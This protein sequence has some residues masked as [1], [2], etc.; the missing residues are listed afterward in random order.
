MQAYLESNKKF[1]YQDAE[2]P[3]FVISSGSLKLD[4]QM[5]GGLRPGVLRLTGNTEGGKTNCALAFARNFLKT[6]DNS[7][8]IYFRAEGR[9]TDEVLIRH[10]LLNHPHVQV[11][12]G[13]VYEKI[14][15][16]IADLINNN[17]TGA[18]YLFII[19][20]ADAMIPLGDLDKKPEEANKVSGGAVLTSDMLRRMA[21]KFIAFGHVCLIISQKRDQ[22]SIDKYAAKDPRVTNASGGNALL[23]Y[24]DWILEFQYRYYGDLITSEPEQK[25]DILGHNCKI[26]FR[27]TPNE[28]T[29]VKVEY[30]IRYGRV[31]GKS[32]WVEREIT[33]VMLAFGMLERSGSWINIIDP[34][35][36][37]LKT[38]GI[39]CIE[40]IQ[41]QEKFV[42]YLEATPAVTE[43]LYKKL[44]DTLKK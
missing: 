19:D 33:D 38:A 12:K 28:K 35:R 14:I 15:G 26:I 29:Y 24:S 20:S 5:G 34:I 18:K 37:E 9:L 32:V 21:N 30:P 40:K 13:N 43:Y 25:G 3:A 42:E 27:K 10:G 44:C 4:I 7:Y 31:D 22:V 39:E 23:H 1:F 8:V 36:A 16:F 2:E 6:V 17:P 41:G 11:V